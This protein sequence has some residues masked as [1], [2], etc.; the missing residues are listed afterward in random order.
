MDNRRNNVQPP[1]GYPRV[2]SEQQGGGKKKKGKCCGSGRNSATAKRGEG[3]FIEGWCVLSILE[4]TQLIKLAAPDN[5]KLLDCC[6]GKAE[7]S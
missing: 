7:R 4:H 2:D 6:L 1:P 5:P 3:S